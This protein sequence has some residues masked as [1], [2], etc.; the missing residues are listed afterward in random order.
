[1]KTLVLGWFSFEFYGATAG[2]LMAKDVVCE[3]LEAARHSFD[4]AL[5][6]PFEGGV[7][8]RTVEP[9]QYTHI[10]FVCGPFGE[11]PEGA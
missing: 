8:W 2:D 10:L 4:V 11:S 7:D 5:E 1:M 9:E 3:W 6:K